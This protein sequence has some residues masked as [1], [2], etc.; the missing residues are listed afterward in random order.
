MNTDV[1]VRSVCA[2]LMVAE[3]R[4][5]LSAG[6][7]ILSRGEWGFLGRDSIGMVCPEFRVSNT[8]KRPV[9]N[10]LSRMRVVESGMEE[11]REIPL[12][13]F[14]FNQFLLVFRSFVPNLSWKGVSQVCVILLIQLLTKMQRAHTSWVWSHVLSLHPLLQYCRG[15]R[16]SSDL[17]T[18]CP[19]FPPLQC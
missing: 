11:I 4:R 9:G 18:V 14:L 1:R 3:T 5:G 19:P 2:L 7:M 15:W 17:S 13:G 12:A 8:R 16:I 10:L 6:M